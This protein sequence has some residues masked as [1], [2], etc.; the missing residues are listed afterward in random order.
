YNQLHGVEGSTRT[1]DTSSN[2]GHD[3]VIEV[4]EWSADVNVAE[5][6]AD[7]TITATADT[8]S[9]NPSV[10][11]AGSSATVCGDLTIMGRS[12]VVDVRLTDAGAKIK[13]SFSVNQTRWGI[14]PFTAMMGGTQG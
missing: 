1:R 12:V 4:E 8:H 9:L 7:T 11:V 10:K 5:D 13:G 2:A 6:P 3:L 14:K